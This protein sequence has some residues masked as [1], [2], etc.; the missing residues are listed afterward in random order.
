MKSSPINWLEKIRKRP[1]MDA[2]GW[3][4]CSGLTKFEAEQ[5]LDWLEANGYGEREAFYEEG[6]GFTVRWR[7]H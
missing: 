7:H 5:V 2:G 3:D 4:R 1:D 6:Q